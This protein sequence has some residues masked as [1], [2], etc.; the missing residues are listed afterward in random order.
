MKENALP[1]SGRRFYPI[2]LIE[3]IKYSFLYLFNRWEYEIGVLVYYT[4]R[5]KKEYSSEKIFQS[6][7]L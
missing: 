1:S 6:F 7:Y 5:E 3:M 2:D 4:P